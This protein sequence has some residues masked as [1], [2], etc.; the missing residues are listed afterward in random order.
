M[1]MPAGVQIRGAIYWHRVTIP[2]D[3]QHLYPRTA[4]GKVRTTHSYVS[5]ETSD[6]REAAVRALRRKADLEAEFIAKREGAKATA[7]APDIVPTPEL[8]RALARQVAHAILGH[9]DAIRYDPSALPTFLRAFEYLAPPL[10]FFTA[11]EVPAYLRDDPKWPARYGMRPEQLARLTEIHRLMATVHTTDLAMGSLSLAKGY[12]QSACRSLGLRVDW[13]RP[14][15]RQALLGILRAATA[16]WIDRGRKDKGEVVETPEAPDALT[17]PKAPAA[18]VH[19]KDVLPE[20]KAKRQ[21]STDALKRTNLALRRLAESGMDKPINKFT[22]ADGARL[23]DWFR[24][25]VRGI[26]HK[27]A[28]NM[29]NALGA[30]MNIA[31]EYEKGIDRNPWA[32]LEFEV[33]DS[34]RRDEFTSEQL[35]KLFETTLFTQGAYRPIYSVQAW[36]A[37]YVMLLGLW[38]G[39]RV[40]ELGQLETADVQVQSGIPVVCIHDDAEGSTIKTADSE[41]TL[42][43]PPELIRLGFLDFVEDQRRAGQTKLFPSL[44]REGRRPP[45]EVMSEWVKGYRQ[46]LGLPAGALNGFHKFRHTVRSALAAHN[47]GTEIADAL[48]GHAPQGSAG[49]T[50]YTHVRPA[51]ILRAL[52]LPLYPFLSLQRI[53]RPAVRGGES[54]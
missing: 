9:D 30:L 10:R 51:A 38:T 17:L 3:L 7:A 26:K 33:A 50:I 28:K 13:D 25:P 1:R 19:L 18:P 39:S 49:R 4:S 6:P 43:V 52:E 2:K 44:H 40:G 23:R 35:Q 48:T 24:D 22:K 21:P 42:P 36:D 53:H 46:D 12:A 27:T 16:A 41:R 54:A 29:W 31:A 37:Y 11:G 5:L 47:V 15:N 34:E 45:G 14:E 8:S 32:G 20:W